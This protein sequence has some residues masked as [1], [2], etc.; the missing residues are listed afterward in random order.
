MEQSQPNKFLRHDDWT[1]IQQENP[2]TPAKG[3]TQHPTD[4]KQ[5]KVGG[6]VG[7]IYCAGANAAWANPFWVPCTIP[8]IN[9]AI[10]SLVSGKWSTPAPIE[11][12]IAVCSSSDPT[13][14]QNRFKSQLKRISPE[15]EHLAYVLA[16]W[17]D[18]SAGQCI[19]DVLV[20]TCWPLFSN[21][22][23]SVG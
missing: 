11:L 19:E 16:T 14:E 10:D 3:G 21:V 5:V 9:A 20:L 13:K 7:R 4:F 1:G 22:F 18:V 17:R 6:E 8:L 15:E 23:F 2:L 12:T